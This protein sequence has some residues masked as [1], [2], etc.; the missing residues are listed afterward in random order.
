MIGK[1]SAPQLAF[2]DNHGM[3]FRDCQREYGRCTS[4]MYRDGTNK[5]GRNGE[6]RQS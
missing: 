4:L 3:L 5:P 6:L 1:D 2:T